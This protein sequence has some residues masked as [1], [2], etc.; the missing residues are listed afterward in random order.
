[1]FIIT[2]INKTGTSLVQLHRAVSKKTAYPFD[3][4]LIKEISSQVGGHMV[5][6]WA[7]RTEF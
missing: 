7:F 5:F 3:K 6:R 4:S 2:F 1:M